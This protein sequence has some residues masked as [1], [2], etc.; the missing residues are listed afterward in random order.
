ME[1]ISLI[2]VIVAGISAGVVT[3]LVGASAVMV[4]A[5]LL[6]IFTGM[7]A[8]VAIGL[9]LCTDVIASLFAA[10]VYYKNK[11]INLTSIIPLLF[12]S[13][14]GITAGSYLSLYIPSSDLSG[15]T[16]VAI[17]FIGL[18]FITKS[19]SKKQE[20]HFF[21]KI[22]NSKKKRILTLSILGLVIG[23]ISG[24]FG[25]GGGM[26]MLVVLVF[27]LD[28]TM[29]TAIGTSI[30]VMV[31][32]AFF[33]AISHF[34]YKPFSIFF[35]IIACIGAFFGAVFSAK[36]ANKMSETKLR[37]LVGFILAILGLALTVK[38]LFF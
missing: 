9:S 25:A 20:F 3:G 18:L 13:F 14:I 23:L 21:E 8:Y 32:M 16:G 19:H 36:I 37:R 17:F 6:I 5:P 30:A 24:T 4:M 28:Y 26:M 1:V 31:I 22:K 33:G 7:E 2:V 10:K 27:L 29:H 15:V 11:N 35:L 38:I 12:F 34:Y